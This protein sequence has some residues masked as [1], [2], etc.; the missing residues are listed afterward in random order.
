M[1]KEG[2]RRGEKAVL[3][4]RRGRRDE[5]KRSEKKDRKAGP[6]VRTWVRR[7]RNREDGGR[8][9]G[10]GVSGGQRGRG[11]LEKGQK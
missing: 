10:K 4:E 8:E 5:G 3:G 2:E 11:A 1:R 6:R 9:K 7:G